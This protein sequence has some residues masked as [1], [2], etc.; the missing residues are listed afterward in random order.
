MCDTFA[1]LFLVIFVIAY[2]VLLAA[3]AWWAEAGGRLR[4]SAKKYCGLA[5]VQQLRSWRILQERETFASG[6]HQL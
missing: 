3:L 1:Q 2:V 6:A 5:L 4:F